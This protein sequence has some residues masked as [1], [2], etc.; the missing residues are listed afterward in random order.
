MKGLG[1]SLLVALLLVLLAIED[2]VSVSRSIDPSYNWPSSVRASST[3]G[4]FF[5]HVQKKMTIEEAKKTIK[6]LR[7]VCSKKNDTPKGIT[8]FLGWTLRGTR[9]FFLLSW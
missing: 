6:N 2:T 7:K 1:V 5:L 8:L 4:F 9:N 3:F